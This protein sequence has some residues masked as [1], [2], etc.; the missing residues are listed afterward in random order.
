M[1]KSLLLA[2]LIVGVVSVIFNPL[3]AVATHEPADKA[4]ATSANIDEVDDSVVLLQEKMR[5]SS[6]SDLI[7]Q[8]TAECT[9]LT[10]LFTEGGPLAQEET[11]GAFGQ[12]RMWITID[13][14]TVPV[15]TFD[16]DAN[17]P[18][19]QT[20]DGAVVFCNRA[21]ARTV[22]DR[23]ENEGPIGPTGTNGQGDGIDEEDDFIRTRTANGFNWLAFNVGKEYDTDRN[24][25][26]TVRLH[27]SFTKLPQDCGTEE[28]DSALGPYGKTCA[29]AYVGRRSL[30][31]EPTHASVHEQS[32][33]AD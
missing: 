9:I 15:S 11:D 14:K 31:I 23:E 26:V 6:T 29:D 21:Y 3:G 27:G 20:D 13:G 19:V 12:V 17:T 7:L 8:T 16:S 2:A 1:K 30:I 10:S 4:A 33:R 18:G 32:G 24:N 22:A 5:V 28:A 25:V